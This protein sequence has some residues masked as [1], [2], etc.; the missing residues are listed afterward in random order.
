ML[1]LQYRQSMCLIN[2]FFRTFLVVAVL[3]ILVSCTTPTRP[4]EHKLVVC[5]TFDD[6]YPS[7][8]ENALPEMNK[9]GFRATTFI[10]SGLIG[11]PIY[12]SWDK[13]TE[14]KNEYNWEIGGHT[15]RHNNLSFLN[16]EQAEY[17]IKAD[18]DSLISRGFNPVSFATSFGICPVEYYSIIKKYYRN[19]RTCFDNQMYSPINRAFIGSTYASQNVTPETIIS[20]I[21]QA[22]VNR[23]NLVV[24][25]FHRV[26]PGL[27][28]DSN[29][30]PEQFA[31]LMKKLHDLKVTVLPLNEAIDYLEKD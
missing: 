6:N 1:N 23:E 12:L 5:I 4:E 9:Y 27:N 7:V 28:M 11:N 29:Y 21:C 3:I 15:L 24:L 25:L 13:L 18:Y 8:Y 19:I 17:V 22:A 16:Y 31:R 14:L 26:S 20:R 30:E 2:L 10:N